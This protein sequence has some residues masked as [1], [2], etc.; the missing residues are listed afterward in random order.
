METV[1][2]LANLKIFDLQNRKKS[3]QIYNDDNL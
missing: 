2:K 3:S 1:E